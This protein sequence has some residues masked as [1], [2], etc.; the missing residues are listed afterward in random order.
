[1]FSGVPQGSVLGLVLFILFI[2]NASSSIQ[3]SLR[4]FA[5]DCVVFREVANFK[6][7]QALQKTWHF[8]FNVSK[9]FHLGITLKTTPVDFKYSLNGKLISKVPATTNLGLHIT[10][11]LS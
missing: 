6:D 4:L 5:D 10:N 2:N 9:S 1:M 11:N 3:S 8:T 7:C